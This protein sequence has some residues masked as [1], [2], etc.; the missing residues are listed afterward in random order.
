MSAPSPDLPTA[1]HPVIFQ[2]L[3]T[4][5]R[6]PYSFREYARRAAW[7]AVQATLIRFSFPW[8]RGWRRFWLR[9]FGARLASTCNIRSS[10]IIR[11][12]WLLEIGEHSALADHVEIYNL[13]PVK[14][15][16]HTVLSQDAYVCAGTHEYTRPD[17]PLIRPPVTIGSG[18]WICAGAFIGP[19]VT[20]GDNTVI[21]ARAVVGRDV[22]SGVVAGGN[23]CKVIKDRPMGASPVPSR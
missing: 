13:G 4:T 14:I 16:S 6:Y 3:D 11:H 2:R 12:P 20:I 1:D 19:G 17:L 23:P 22:P 8:S 7:I 18:V 5:A 9:A 10:T 21:A 15:G